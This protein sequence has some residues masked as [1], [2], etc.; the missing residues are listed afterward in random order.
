MHLGWEVFFDV[1]RYAHILSG[2]LWIGLL[3]YFNF[4]QVPAFAKMEPAAR[5][6][7]IMILVPRV[8]LYFRY[9][10]LSTVIFGITFI[11][12]T[13]IQ[14]SGYWTTNR[15]YSIVVGGT[16]GL[17][18]AANV[19]FIIWPNQKKVIAATTAT[20]KEGKPAPPDQP[21]WARAT[22]VASRSNVI[23]SIP[24]LFFMVGAIHLD[25]LWA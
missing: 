1:T 6:N 13:A 23:M 9:A 16:L 4:A 18:M 25:S 10:A 3:Y 21:K 5:Q 7:A 12:G 2:I 14:E 8:L 19:W 22:L 20:V 15:F 24:M 17:V 11:V